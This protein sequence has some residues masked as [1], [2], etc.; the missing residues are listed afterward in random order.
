MLRERN[1]S[2]VLRPGRRHLLR[3]DA[4][5][6]LLRKVFRQGRGSESVETRPGTPKVLGELGGIAELAFDCATVRHRILKL[7]AGSA[8][9]SADVHGDRVWSFDGSL[10]KLVSDVHGDLHVAGF[11]RS[12][13][14]GLERGRSYFVGDVVSVTYTVNPAR[15]PHAFAEH[16]GVYPRLFYRDGFLFFRGGT[17]SITNRGLEG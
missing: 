8:S 5:E 6:S 1:Y 9:L 13:P 11:Y 17:Y 14:D 12:L 16:G 4:R 10:V 3:G 2:R 15:I 7:L